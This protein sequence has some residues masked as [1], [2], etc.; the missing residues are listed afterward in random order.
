MDFTAP[1]E[2]EN[3]ETEAS[4]VHE[5]ILEGDGLKKLGEGAACGPYP[6]R[7]QC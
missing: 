2:V 1:V 4:Q 5:D 6:G 7:S 3:E